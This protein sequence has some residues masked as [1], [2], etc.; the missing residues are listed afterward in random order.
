MKKR[1]LLVTDFSNNAWN[2]IVY[3]LELYKEVECSFYVLNAFNA[4][5]YLKSS[6]MIP[7]PG[8]VKY[9]AAKL[10]SEEGLVRA[11]RKITFRE[12]NNPKHTYS[13]ISTFNG[14]L[15]A[16]LKAIEEKDIDLVVMGTK[17]ETNASTIIYGSNAITLMEK[18]RNCP[19]LVVPEVTDSIPPKEIVFPTSY[20]THF[21]RKEL[22]HLIEIAKISDS[23]I[24][25]LHVEKEDGLGEKQLNNKNLLEECFEEV[26]Y[27]F[28]T[29][30]NMEVTAAVNCFVESRG[31]DMV[32]FINKKHKFFGSILTQPLVKNLGYYTKVPVLVMH[33]LR[34]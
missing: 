16:T 17:G 4:S 26:D 1:I 7:E 29:L 28:H 10:E 12:E 23:S 22:S 34:N 25:I 3:A 11:M 30:S 31:S 27:S 9:E 8:E 6:L 18:I 24:K 19:V 32:A 21:K 13:T 20:K 15:E 14:L 33:D 5:G 2:A